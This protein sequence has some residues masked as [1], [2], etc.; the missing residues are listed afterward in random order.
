MNT[1]TYNTRR[2][3]EH[4][5]F[6]TASEPERQSIAR[7]SPLSVRTH[8]RQHV[9]HRS[10]LRAH[11]HTCSYTHAPAR[12]YHN[13]TAYDDT[14]FYYFVFFFG[15]RFRLLDRRTGRLF[16]SRLLCLH[17]CCKK[18]ILSPPRG[19]HTPV[20]RPPNL[21]ATAISSRVAPLLLPVCG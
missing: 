8:T 17:V 12:A 10:S 15:F 19:L 6:T 4:V 14:R 1:Y 13:R 2:V 3:H 11:S 20:R 16:S 7:R 5:I 9:R 18:I 21:T